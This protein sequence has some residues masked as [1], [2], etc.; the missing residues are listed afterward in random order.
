MRVTRKNADMRDFG[1][2]SA[3]D[4]F[5]DFGEVYIKIANNVTYEGTA[6]INAINLENGSL[7][8]YTESAP[9]ELVN[10]ELVIE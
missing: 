5:V 8:S 7:A 1:N 9:V 3:G 2:L 4:V 6:K 10:A